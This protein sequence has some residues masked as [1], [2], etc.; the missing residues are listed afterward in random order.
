MKGMKLSVSITALIAISLFFTM[1]F[2]AAA[3]LS[4]VELRRIKKGIEKIKKSPKGVKWEGYRELRFIGLATVPYLVELLEDKTVDSG[5]KAMV[6]DLLGDLKA[7]E[8]V[9]VL[10]KVL[11]HKMHT[12]RAASSRALGVIGDPAAVKPLLG[13]LGDKEGGVRE[14]ATYALMNF[15]DST[16]PP[17]VAV[18]LKDNE[19]YV[20]LAAIKLL[21]DKLDP[22]TTAAIRQAFQS[23]KIHEIRRLAAKALGDLK[24]TRSVDMLMKALTYEYTNRF[25]REECAISLGKIGDKKAIPALIEALKDDYKDIQLRASYSLKNITGKNFGRDHDKWSSWYKGE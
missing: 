7:K 15:N 24:D 13:R 21:G 8:A 14:L 5:T 2:C 11:E 18:L 6:C 4:S 10:I 12:V 3:E 16:I 9:P 23:E 1:I 22:K 19:E 25:V 17:K 20:R